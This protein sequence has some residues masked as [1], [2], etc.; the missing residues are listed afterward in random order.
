MKII[1]KWQ[2]WLFYSVGLL[3]LIILYDC[4]IDESS[5]QNQSKKVGF[6]FE[7]DSN[8]TKLNHQINYLTQ[9]S[10]ISQSLIDRKEN[11]AWA[12][13]ALYLT[14]LGLVFKFLHGN[15]P[16]KKFKSIII[17][18]LI[19]LAMAISVFAFIHAQYSSIYDTNAHAN[20]ADTLLQV[21]ID[22]ERALIN[23]S[24]Y[25]RAY[26]NKN[27]IISQKFRGKK[28]PWKILKYFI[29]GDW[30]ESS[31]TRVLN[32]LNTQEAA[33][34]FMMILLN[35]VLIIYIFNKKFEINFFRR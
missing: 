29:L 34:Y 22:S 9:K 26:Y 25:R 16:F 23:L 6:I 24:D 28:H 32:S 11:A 8:K 4:T 17:V 2:K 31:N 33:L 3:L 20:A 5:D 35:V 18:S 13:F 14:G 7:N 12:A 15:K 1:P 27:L 19:I 10:A 21:I 30:T